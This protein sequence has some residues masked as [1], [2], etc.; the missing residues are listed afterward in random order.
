MRWAN[1]NIRSDPKPAEPFQK[2]VGCY[3]RPSKEQSTLRFLQ[4]N[5]QNMISNLNKYELTS[6]ND[7]HE[8]RANNEIMG[9]SFLSFPHRKEMR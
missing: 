9:T 8:K 7:D 4:K 6:L 3:H 1:K 2:N 5:D